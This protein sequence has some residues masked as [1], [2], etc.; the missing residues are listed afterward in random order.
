LAGLLI[1]SF[2]LLALSTHNL[3]EHAF[4]RKDIVTGTLNLPES[5]FDMY[6]KILGL[7]YQQ[8]P[9][10]SQLAKGI[11]MWILFSK[12]TLSA[13][14]LG[15]ALSIDFEQTSSLD[16]DAIPTPRAIEKSCMGLVCLDEHLMVSFSHATVK[17][18]LAVKQDELD[19]ISLGPERVTVCCLTNLNYSEFIGDQISSFD[20]VQRLEDYTFGEYASQNWIT[21]IKDVKALTRE[22][23][24]GRLLT[25]RVS[26][27]ALDLLKN[28]EKPY[29]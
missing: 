23:P 10:Q 14:E 5:L 1:V 28:A 25:D 22:K 24:E 11:L 12:R 15:E 20:I 19:W 9:A 18:Y 17:E 2:Q 21:H 4:D 7:I 3:L 16:A 29:I 26:T 27:L 6:D 8:K 13:Q